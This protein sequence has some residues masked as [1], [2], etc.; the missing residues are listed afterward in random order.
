MLIGDPKQAIYAFRGADV[1]AYLDAA[2]SRGRQRDARRQLAQRPAAAR[3]LRRAL[4]RRAARPSRA[5]PTAPCSAAPP[6]RDARLAGAPEGA[7]LRVRVLPRDDPAVPLTPSR[8]RLRARRPRARR[9]RRRGATS[10]GCSAPG[11]RSSHAR[12]RRRDAAHGARRARRRR[13]ARPLAPDGRAGPRRARRGRRAGRDRRRGQRVRHRARARLAQAAR[14][15]RAA[16]ARRA[17]AHRRAHPVPRLGRGRG[18]ACATEEEW[19]A[20]HARLHEWAELLRTHGVASLAEA[21]TA[22]ER[23]PGRMLG[24]VEGERALTDLRH[25]GELLHE[26]ATAEHLGVTAL[27]AWLRRRIAAAEQEGDEERSRRL[28]SDAAAVQVLT[29]HR[30]K[31]LEFP[32]VYLPFLWEPTWLPEGDVP[33]GFHDPTRAT[34]G[35]STSG[36]DGPKWSAHKRQHLIE[37]RGEDLRLAYVAL[38]RARHQA[39][40]WWAGSYPS[41]HSALGRLLFARDG[42]A[43]RWEGSGDAGGRRRLRQAGGADAGARAAASAP[44]AP[45]RR[46]RT[47][48]AGRRTRRA[49]LAVARF[50]R[51]LDRSWRRTS[52]SDLTAGAYEARAARGRRGGVGAR[53]APRRRAWPASP[54][55]RSWPTSRAGPVAPD[56][57]SRRPRSRMRRCWPCPSPLAGMEGGTRAGTFVHRVLERDRLRRGRPR[58]GARRRRASTT[59]ACAPGCAAAIETPLGPLVGEL[60]LARRRARRPARRAG[61]RAPARGRGRAAAAR[62]TSPPSPTSC[63]ATAARLAHYAERLAD[64]VLRKRGA[65]LPDRQPRPGRPAPGRALRD[66]RPQDELARR[67]RRGAHRVA[68]PAR[69]ARRRDGARALRPAGAALHGRAAPLPALAAARSR[70]GARHRGRPVPVRARDARAGHARDRRWPLRRLRLAARAGAGRRSCRRCSTAGHGGARA[71]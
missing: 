51:E 44:S 31:G 13:G 5:S 61:L 71:A 65:R 38:T 46:R 25:V 42:E 62:S 50:G 67:A 69:R 34:R 7:P 26:A 54:R 53:G 24:T 22:A 63:G 15:A 9:A 2:R 60:R 6:N 19:G 11:R 55:R 66:R 16:R 39:V 36:L 41:R 43:V 70:S 12:R 23:L 20:L 48:G 8:L 68:L 47:G 52:Y 35:R 40:L 21:I 32:I 49:P 10:R 29:I 18:V 59:P 27:A 30:S 17:R 56:G 45:T 14:G 4:R 33:I 37:E 64:P 58:R 1:Y 3:R 57:A 28:E